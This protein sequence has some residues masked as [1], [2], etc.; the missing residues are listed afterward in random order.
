M[1]RRSAGPRLYLDPSRKQWV[2]RDGSHFVRTGCPESAVDEAQKLLGEYLGSKHK[3]QRSPAPLID[4]VLVTYSNEHLPHTRAAKNA[5]YQVASLAAWWS[6]K[7]TTDVTALNCRAYAEGRTPA[8]ARRDLEVLRAAIGYWHKN[9]GPLPSVPFVTMPPK[10]EPRD[11]WLTR[12]EAR[13]LRHAAR[14]TP[15]LYRF[16]VLGLLTGSRVG[17]ILALKW[18]WIDFDRGIMRRREPGAA[19]DSRKRTPPFRMGRALT[20]LLRGWQRQDGGKTEYVVHYD[21]RPVTR[22]KRSWAGACKRAK[23]TDVSPHTL[24]HTRAT[25]MMQEGVDRWQAAGALG[26]SVDMLDQVYGHHSP[27]FQKDAAEV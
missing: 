20:R 9:Y 23:L 8:A 5:T 19:E 6:G 16:I 21:G 12:E 14:G 1:P 18:D 24:R 7:R 26:M 17:S 13:R 4:D 3:P 25:W 22:I 11:R 15:H 10:S 2:I 27:D